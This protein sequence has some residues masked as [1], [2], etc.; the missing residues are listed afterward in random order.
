MESLGQQL[1]LLILFVFFSLGLTSL[2]RLFTLRASQSAPAEAEARDALP[3]EGLALLGVLLSYA[4]GCNGLLI[5]PALLEVLGLPAPW[6]LGLHHLALAGCL[7]LVVAVA[8]IGALALARAWGGIGSR[9]R[10]PFPVPDRLSLAALA[11]SGG[12]YLILAQLN[13]N[14]YDLGIYHLPYVNHLVSFGPELGLANLHARFGFYNVQFFGQVPWQLLSG[15]PGLISPSLNII[16]F[17]AFLLH[18]FSA[19]LPSVPQPSGARHTHL[20]LLALGLTVGLPTLGS[21]AG[22]DAD[23]ALSAS[24]LM[25]IDAVVRPATATMRRACL[26]L[27]ALLPLIKLSGVLAVLAVGGFLVIESLLSGLF[28]LGPGE[29]HGAEGPGAAAPGPAARP[30]AAALPLLLAAWL[31]LATTGILQSGYPLFPSVTLGPIGHQAVSRAGT[32]DL[33][34]RAITAYA[35]FNDDQAGM[36]SGKVQARAPL[37][38]WLPAFLGSPRGHQLMAWISAALFASLAGLAATFHRSRDRW[39]LSLTALSLTT[40]GLLLLA[41]LGLPPNPRFFA[42]L[43]ALAFVVALETL[44]RRPLLGL[45]GAGLLAVGLAA[46]GHRSLLVGVGRPPVQTL[47]E[48]RRGLHGWS[49]RQPGEQ[50]TIHQ[51]RQGDQCW[52][53]P[54]PCSPSRAGLEDGQAGNLL[55]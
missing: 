4:I 10:F 45:V 9:W 23:F 50:V 34:E 36:A 48:E 51:P 26:P 24:I 21:L 37:S 33:Q 27:V 28:K 12:T 42:W 29:G 47:Q 43:G 1:M 52:A 7:A 38:R 18:F 40:L 2:A 30:F 25:V 3:G 13:V 32:R 5:V 15:D 16:F 17:Q 22:F 54:A 11:I 46:K 39:V 55:R 19:I 35:R 8:L 49:S 44:W 20:L 14:S 31:C 6:R 53:V 41:L